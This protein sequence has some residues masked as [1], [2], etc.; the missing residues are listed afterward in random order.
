[1]MRRSLDNVAVGGLSFQSV[2]LPY[3]SG[4]RRFI[5]NGDLNGN[6]KKDTSHTR[7]IGGSSCGYYCLNWCHH[8]KYI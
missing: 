5:S 3:S 8:K 2:L 7:R 6:Y 4:E 1:M